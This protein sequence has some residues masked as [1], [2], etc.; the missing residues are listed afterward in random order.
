MKCINDMA[1]GGHGQVITQL[2]LSDGVIDQMCEL[3]PHMYPA[4]HGVGGQSA[5][6]LTRPFIVRIAS[7]CAILLTFVSVTV[8]GPMGLRVIGSENAGRLT[9]ASAL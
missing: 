8:H 5:V 9:W 2:D 3:Y 1:I 4:H 6:S 7:V